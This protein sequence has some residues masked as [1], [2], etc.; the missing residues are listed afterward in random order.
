MSKSLAKE[1]RVSVLQNMLLRNLDEA[2]R[3]AV[4][5]YRPNTDSIK[6]KSAIFINDEQRPA[7]MVNKNIFINYLSQTNRI[8]NEQHSK[9]L[10]M[11]A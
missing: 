7:K 11:H 9:P 1:P 3:R 4:A 6:A 8:N 2:V 5:G 10:M